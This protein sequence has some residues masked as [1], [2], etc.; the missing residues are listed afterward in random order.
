ML[1]LR[2]RIA[3]GDLV[4]VYEDFRNLHAVRVT[5]PQILEL[6]HG[7]LSHAALVGKRYGEPAYLAPWN[8]RGNG[9][10][11]GTGELTLPDGS[12]YNGEFQNGKYHGQGRY[13]WAKTGAVYDGD[14]QNDQMEGSGNFFSKKKISSYK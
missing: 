8:S 9:V 6:H 12:D 11:S 10:K 4:I 14:W 1:T 3:A 7:K 2:P 5:P 13:F